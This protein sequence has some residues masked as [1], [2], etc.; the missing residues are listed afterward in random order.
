VG[1]DVTTPE[2]REGSQSAGL[3]VAVLDN[4]P[5]LLAGITEVL[6][7]M[8]MAAHGYRTPEDLLAALDNGLAAQCLV[9]DQQLDDGATGLET[10]RACYTRGW[11]LPVVIISAD[12]S[13]ELR[14]AVRD[15]G[16]RFMAKPLEPHRLRALI[17]AL[18][19][20]IPTRIDAD[21]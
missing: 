19:E 17:E 12:D 4:D 14:S 7:G 2:T 3:K 11:R 20:S 15:E 8:G 10:A 5:S 1:E 16:F 21:T 9:I 13:A 6:V 18:V